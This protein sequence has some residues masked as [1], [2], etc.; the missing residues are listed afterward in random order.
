MR[1]K[2]FTLIELLVVIAIIAILIGLLL[3][4][5]QKVRAAAQR[6]Q[7]SNN[8][9]QLGLAAHSYH[10][11]Y[12]KF[13]PGTALPVVWTQTAP[14]QNSPSAVV[15]GKSFSVLEALLPYIEQDNIYNKL[16]LSGTTSSG[17]QYNKGNTD[18]AGAPGAQVIKTFICPSDDGL[19]PDLVAPYPNATSPTNWFGA[20]SYGGCA[21]ISSFYD[22]DF[23]GIFYINSSVRVSDVTDGSSNTLAFG[24]RYHRDP[25]YDKVVSPN[26]NPI[27]YR[28]G[29]AWANGLGGFDYLLGAS[30]PINWTIPTTITT[31]PAFTYQDQRM[32]CFGSGHPGGANFCFADGSVRFLADST[33]LT[34][35]L[36]PLCT[37]NRG[38]V[39]PGNAF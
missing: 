6:A 35:V 20:N 19:P 10:G 25:T 24:E 5:V 30:Q 37:R 22:K 39:I 18:S 2:G 13:P 9:K 4:A 8:L 29:W 31:D 23:L 11:V 3:P 36:Q 14:L 28:T 16:D 32:S 33:D 38:E 27:T 21:G 12:K 26:P 34:S 1:R 7:C 15:P 17:S